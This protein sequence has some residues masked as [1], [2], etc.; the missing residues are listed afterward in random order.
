MSK[1]D[2]AIFDLDNTILNGDSDYSMVNYLVDINLLDSNAKLKN[3]DFIQDYQQGKL[4]FNEY[5]NFALKAY[6]GKTQDEISKIILPFVEKVIEPMINIFAL[7]IN[8]VIG[9]Q[10]E[11]KDSKCTGNFIPPSALGEGKLKLVKAWM[12]AH[13]Y[14]NFSRVTFYSDS[15]ND[16]P[17]LEAVDFPKAVNPDKK[18]EAISNERGWEVIYLPL[19]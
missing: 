19:I 6:I 9:T 18:L 4:D 14:H 7:N 1:P 5:T 12:K 16:L 13:Q 17:L 15:I 3:N 10:V 8:H 2:L 11:F